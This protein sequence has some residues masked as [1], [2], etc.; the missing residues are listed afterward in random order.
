MPSFIGALFMYLFQS[1]FNLIVTSNSGQ[2]ALTMPIMA[3]PCGPGRR[4]TSGG[5]TGFPD[6]SRICGC[7]HTGFRQSHRCPG[8]CQD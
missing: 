3:L 7:V 8:R 6:G 5:S 4:H 2:A 1:C